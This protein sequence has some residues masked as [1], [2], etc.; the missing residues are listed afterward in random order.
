MG[1][2]QQIFIYIYC[3]ETETSQALIQLIDRIILKHVIRPETHLCKV[4]VTLSLI[5]ISHVI[6]FPYDRHRNHHCTI[7]GYWLL[8]S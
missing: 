5:I 4:N 8:E 7:S 2:L 6:F 3:V 1:N